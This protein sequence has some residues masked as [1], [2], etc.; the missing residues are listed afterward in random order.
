M[1]NHLIF[2][3]YKNHLSVHCNK[4]DKN[5][6]SNSTHYVLLKKLSFSVILS[7]LLSDYVL[8]YTL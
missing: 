3:L 4:I 8:D 6:S 7:R 5:D 2:Q 1:Y